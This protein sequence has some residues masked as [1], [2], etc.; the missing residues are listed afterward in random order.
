MR[1]VFLTGL[2][3]LFVTLAVSR[4]AAQSP[5]VDYSYEYHGPGITTPTMGRVFTQGASVDQFQGSGSIPATFKELAAHPGLLNPTKLV[6]ISP[7]AVGIRKL[8]T[9][10]TSVGTASTTASCYAATYINVPPLKPHY[11]VT[12]MMTTPSVTTV[13]DFYDP[14]A[15]SFPEQYGRS[16][17]DASSIPTAA[18]FAKTASGKFRWFWTEKAPTSS[19]TDTIFSIDF[20]STDVLN[21]PGVY[22][23]PFLNGPIATLIGGAG[24]AGKF[25]TQP[26]AGN[27]DDTA[28][29]QV[30]V[31]TAGLTGIPGATYL[32][33]GRSKDLLT[34][35]PPTWNASFTIFDSESVTFPMPTVRTWDSEAPLTNPDCFQ[36]MK[37]VGNYLFATVGENGASGGGSS[38][39]CWFLPT[40]ITSGVFTPAG[41]WS[42][43]GA[44][45]VW[46][47]QQRSKIYVGSDASSN[48]YHVIAVSAGTSALTVSSS[49]VG[50]IVSS[51][52][53][54]TLAEQS[55][56]PLP[57]RIYPGYDG[58]AFRQDST[59]FPGAGGGGGSGGGACSASGE[60]R[61]DTFVGIALMLVLVGLTT[62]TLRAASKGI[63]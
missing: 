32:I 25:F 37:V 34:V 40:V 50:G 53:A 61:S 49:P 1:T 10:G 63:S 39:K 3:V 60:G 13:L 21:G 58:I 48:F 9:G 57:D 11:F 51:Y 18:A 6:A 38:L 26:L 29:M 56:F 4:P 35:T 24:W 19:D 14:E 43:A 17:G 15:E 52:V 20:A 59:L 33:V 8:S 41:T 42:I 7:G 16:H 55:G 36:D 23:P 62:M 2:A 47:D 12:S 5:I 54:M 31:D 27:D 22:G 30:W 28:R 46:I 44:S 45:G